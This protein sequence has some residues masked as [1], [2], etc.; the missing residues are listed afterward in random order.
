VLYDLAV[1]RLAAGRR[2]EALE[3]L[4]RAV[5]LN[6]GLGTQA[7]ADGDLAGLARD[8]A[9][10]KLQTAP[11]AKVGTADGALAAGLKEV[12]AW[13]AAGMTADGPAY[14]ASLEQGGNAKA[15]FTLKAGKCYVLVGYATQ[16]GVQ[17]FDLHIWKTRPAPTLVADDDDDDNSPTV[18]KPPICPEA[19]TGYVA[20][21]FAEK[22]KGDA[23]LQLY[24]KPK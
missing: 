19:D 12:A 7:R 21:M 4:G 6:P 1:I 23:A 10:Q 8:P 18:G 14:T 3:A 9:F 15:A 5:E 16:G 2:P 24:S 11:A 20:E 22:G 17:D 13:F